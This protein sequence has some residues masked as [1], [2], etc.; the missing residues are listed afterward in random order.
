MIPTSN[1]SGSLSWHEL[2]AS[3]SEEAMVFYSQV[4]GWQ[5][6]TI[7]VA[8]A[9]YHIIINNGVDI[10]GIAQSPAPA[11]PSNWTGYITV[12]NVDE[13]ADKAHELGANILFGPEDIIGIGRF[14]WLKDPQ[15]AIIAA[16][17]YIDAD[18]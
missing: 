11:M 4:F 13:V 18:K 12:K 15:G 6:K 8:D 17:S 7:V 5:F 2:T 9:P 1:S 3:S 10:G 14:C 16:I